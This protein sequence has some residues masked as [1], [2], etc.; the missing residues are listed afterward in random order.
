MGRNAQCLNASPLGQ[1]FLRELLSCL[2]SHLGWVK[3]P[4]LESRSWICVLRASGAEWFLQQPLDRNPS[5]ATVEQKE[6]SREMK[7][8]FYPSG[9][10][11]LVG[12]RGLI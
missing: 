3:A 4:S 1:L 2:E 7:D 6:R 5:L 9:S 11:C 12:K 10:C 8:L